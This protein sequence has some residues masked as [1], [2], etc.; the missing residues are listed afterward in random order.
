MYFL[1]NEKM[2]FWAVN[3]CMVHVICVDKKK[4]IINKVRA[5]ICKL[6]TNINNNIKYLNILPGLEAMLCYFVFFF[7]L[8]T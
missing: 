1:N 8:L 6:T 7:L 2:K 3:I 5:T 4:I